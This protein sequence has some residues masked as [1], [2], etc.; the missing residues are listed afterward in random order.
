MISIL[1]TI[2]SGIGRKA[3]LWGAIAVAIGAALWIAFRRGRL[4]AE[5]EFLIRR[6]DSRVQS[7]QTAKEVSNEVQ[8]ADR[9]DLQRRLDRWMRD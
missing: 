9:A 2:F 6:A 8:N 4:E 5:A 7:L 3:A 1:T